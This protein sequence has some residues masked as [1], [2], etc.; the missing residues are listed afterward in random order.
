M[1][2][3][4]NIRFQLF[5]D[6]LKFYN[7]L[8]ADIQNAKQYIYIETYRW[9]NDQIGIK[10]RDAVTAK[11][12]EGVEVKLLL[13]SWATQVTIPFFSHLVQYGGEVRFYKKIKFYFDFFTKN[14]RRNHRKLYLIDNKISYIGSPNLTGYSINWRE[15]IIKLEDNI[16]F[17]LKKS[18]LDSYKIYNKYI[19]N[20][21]SFKKTIHHKNFEIIQDIPSI[22][23]QQIKK[24][25]EKLILE[26]KKEVIIETPYFLPGYKLRKAMIDASERGVEVKII[27]PEHSDVRSVDILRSRYL[28]P[29]HKSGVKIMFYYP[30]NLHAKCLLT[31]NR[32]FVIGTPNFD[33][34]SFRYQH[35]IALLGQHPEI[36]QQIQLHV[37]ETLGNCIA[38]N[39]DKWLKRPLIEKFFEHLL[40]PFRHLF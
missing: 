37:K 16:T 3:F 2:G 33:Y 34:R 21:F 28:G 6:P 38:F 5:D 30:N 12:K 15:L 4:D 24:R 22:Y 36:I 1:A 23:R 27:V 17:K 32:T 19:F 13:D 9:G 26:A 10:F 40:I 14:H 39:Y 11:A 29:L 25:Y 35:E 31:D 20:K 18:F 7:S 8:L